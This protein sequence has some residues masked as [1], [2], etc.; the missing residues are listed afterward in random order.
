MH[1]RRL[2]RQQLRGSAMRWLPL[3]GSQGVPA[4]HHLP[5]R[6]AGGRRKVLKFRYRSD[7]R[8]LHGPKRT[9]R[10]LAH[11]SPHPCHH[12]SAGGGKVVAVGCKA[13]LVPLV[14]C[15]RRRGPGCRHCLPSQNAWSAL[16]VCSGQPT[17]TPTPS[18]CRIESCE[19]RSAMV[20][21]Q[22]RSSH[23]PPGYSADT[24]A[25]AATAGAG[26]SCLLSISSNVR[27]LGSHPNTQKP[28][29]PRRYHAAK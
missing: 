11:A 12:A 24:R 14:G 4:N 28:I 16:S 10:L 19:I 22:A 9:V 27:P 20:R 29:T 1:L 3:R 7:C 23:R 18:H 25:D 8:R 15:S 17:A 6:L 26:A 13:V 2:A 5:R 21:G